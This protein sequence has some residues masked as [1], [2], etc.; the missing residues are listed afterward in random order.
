VRVLF[1][2][3]LACALLAS[4]RAVWVRR[5]RWLDALGWATI[6]LLVCTAWLLPWYGVWAVVPAALS[7]DRRLR[8]SALG[9]AFYLVATRLAVA[10]PVLG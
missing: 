2:A 9:L 1:A 3:I 5:E 8:W 4:L 6:A 7:N 10:D